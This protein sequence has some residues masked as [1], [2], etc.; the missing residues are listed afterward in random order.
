MLI[1]I[2]WIKDFVSIPDMDPVKLG[3]KFTLACAEV[4]GVHSSGEHLKKMS[5]A[6]VLEIEKHPEADKLNLVTFEIANGEKRKVVCGASNV[7]VGMKTPY[8]PVGT[9][10]PGGFE[11]IPKKIR[12]VLSEGMLCSEEELGLKESSEGILELPDSAPTGQRLDLYFKETPDVLLDIDNKSLTHRPDLWGH[13]GMAR[14]FSAIFHQVMKN[15]FNQNWAQKLE[16]KQ[17]HRQSPITV[18]LEGPSAC[19]GYFGLT[20]ENISVGESPD[21]M[22]KRLKAV[23]LRPINSIVDISNYVM[24][25]LGFPNH[26]FDRDMIE[27]NQVIIK[28]NGKDDKFLT[29]DEI[30]RDLIPSDTVICDAKKTLV[31][32]GIMGGLNSGVS[33]NTKTIFIEVA[34]WKAA[35]VRRTSTR[36]GLRTDSSMRYEKSLD[37]NLMKRTLLRILELVLELNPHAKVVGNIQYDGEKFGEVPPLKKHVM[38]DKI[39]AVLGTKLTRGDVVSILESLDFKVKGEDPLEVT[40]PTYRATK[41]I[42]V[43]DDIIEEIGRII[44]YDNIVP[45]A[46]LWE[47]TPVRLSTSQTLHRKIKDFMSFHARAFEIMNYPLVGQ[48]LFQK[49]SFK[50]ELSGLINALSNDHDHMRSSLIP[51]I[52]DAAEKNAKNYS[53]FHLFELGRVYLADQKTFAKEDS[54]LAVAFYDRDKTPFMD[55]TNTMERLLNQ[56]GIPFDFSKINPK[57]KNPLINESWEGIHPIE[58]LNIRA[59]GKMAGMVMS[60]HPLMLRKFKIKGHLTVAIFNLTQFETAKVTDKTKYRPLPKFPGSKFDCSVVIN[61]N[62][63][64]ADIFECLKKVKINEVESFQ[65]VDNFKMDQDLRSVTIRANIS[66]SEKTLTGELITMAQNK[67]MQTLKEGGFPLKE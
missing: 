65:I 17:D 23:G 4:E 59:M 39:N 7:R 38:L 52:L 15:P 13:F 45:L 26:I 12:G 5:V 30:W 42:E 28:P 24:M 1:S 58:F 53:E 34:N 40:V 14:E 32:G 60:I 16:E 8:A 18:K 66:D 10:L 21:W 47:V 57:F 29:L 50:I 64:V 43:V 20:V 62:Q 25:E 46:P 22:Q 11:L 55:L 6:K 61:A 31:L 63:D 9:V 35:M 33:P 67:I 3:E 51:G 27:G 44:G 2:D 41:D 49:A 19:L 54:H 37:S 56:L 48:D 36:L